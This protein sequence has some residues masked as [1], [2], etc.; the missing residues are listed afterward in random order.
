MRRLRLRLLILPIALLLVCGWAVAQ[1]APADGVDS[2]ETDT[3]DGTTP[4]EGDETDAG[5]EEEGEPG[6]LGTDGTT[7]ELHGAVKGLTTALEA[8]ENR[9]EN[10]VAVLSGNLERAMDRQGVGDGDPMDPVDTDGDL[11]S[12]GDAT[13]SVGD[14]TTET[15]A[16]RFDDVSDV[17]KPAKPER[18][19]RPEKPEKPQR[20]ERPEKPERPGKPDRP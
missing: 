3:P 9:S 7:S 1:E 2:V 6:D 10:A 18:L 12:T 8:S 5:S 13:G 11:E 4:D 19:L 17:E 16:V 15:A 14:T 20:P